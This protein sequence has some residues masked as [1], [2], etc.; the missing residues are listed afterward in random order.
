MINF[1][2]SYANAYEN[3]YQNTYKNTSNDFELLSDNGNKC[4]FNIIIREDQNSTITVNGFSFSGPAELFHEENGIKEYVINQHE[5]ISALTEPTAPAEIVAEA[6]ITV[7]NNSITSIH[8]R[9]FLTRNII[10]QLNNLSGLWTI[11]G[12]SERQVIQT[13]CGQ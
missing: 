8:V 11:F 10:Q 5:Y 4:S 2:L 1:S 12:K 6:H 9:H 7:I 3:T 13:S